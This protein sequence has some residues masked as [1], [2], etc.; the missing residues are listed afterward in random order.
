MT[1]KHYVRLA[2]AGLILGS[3]VAVTELHKIVAGVVYH[4]VEFVFINYIAI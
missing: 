4:A 1:T 2:V 3:I